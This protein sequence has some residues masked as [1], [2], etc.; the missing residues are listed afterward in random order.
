[1]GCCRA[2]GAGRDTIRFDPDIE[3]PNLKDGDGNPFVGQK[4]DAGADGAQGAQGNYDF[5]I[6]RRVNHGDTTNLRTPVGFGTTYANIIASTPVLPTGWVSTIPSFTAGTHDVYES[7]IQVNPASQTVSDWATPFKIDAEAGPTGPAGTPGAAGARGPAGAA[8]VKGDTGDTGPRGIQGVQGVQGEM[9]VAG[10]AGA[11]GDMGDQGPKGDTG[12]DGAAGPPGAAGGAL[13]RVDILTNKETRTS[14]APFSNIPLPSGRSIADF[15]YFEFVGHVGT[16]IPT[17]NIV[18]RETLETEFST[19]SGITI[20]RHTSGNR[21]DLVEARISGGQLQWRLNS[22]GRGNLFGE[23]NRVTGLISGEAGGGGTP[24]PGPQGEQGPQGLGIVRL[25]NK[26]AHNASA[27]TTPTGVTATNAVPPV[28]SGIPA[29][30]TEAF[31][32]FNP[33]TEDVYESFA[34]HNPAAATGSALNFSAPFE[35]GAEIGPAG[36]AGA[37]GAKG[38]DGEQG[39]KGDKGDTGDTGPAGPPG[40]GG[41]GGGTLGGEYEAIVTTRV[42]QNGN[43]QNITLPSGRSLTDYAAF[44]AAFD[45]VV[46]DGPV[47]GNISYD[48]VLAAGAHGAEIAFGLGSNG[49]G[50]LRIQSGALQWSIR[51]NA[52]HIAA[53]SAFGLISLR[54]LRLAEIPADDGGGITSE[55]VTIGT[56]SGETSEGTI[57][58]YANYKQIAIRAYSNSVNAPRSTNANMHV[59]YTIHTGLLAAGEQPMY[60]GGQ[61][62][63]AN[64]FCLRVTVSGTSL[65]LRIVDLNVADSVDQ[66]FQFLR[67]VGYP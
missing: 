16:N 14:I 37:A 3:I 41:G 29:G 59:Q 54:G 8:G 34:S 13:E 1:M 42:N 33:A 30:W 11:K 5:K 62:R 43:W 25:F 40:T 4:G 12:D 63:G 36:P 28:L 66:S 46:V 64:N 24:T 52:G 50:S 27:P 39:P 47:V 58:N 55:V 21:E 61:G 48:T 32:S 57:A 9:G 35:V 2:A 22:T 20:V 18:S 19:G 7:I 23:L 60:L 17:S 65:A 67:A 45:G 56:V 51:N 49:F 53:S 44:E 6:Y 10:A 26:V 38:A 15:E 31:P